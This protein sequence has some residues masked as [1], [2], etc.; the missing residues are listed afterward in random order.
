MDETDHNSDKPDDAC[1]LAADD[2][3]QPARRPADVAVGSS[4]GDGNRTPPR[5]DFWIPTTIAIIGLVVAVASAIFSGLQWHEANQLKK[6]TFRASVSFYFENDKESSVV[7]WSVLNSGP[8]PAKIQ[9]LDY[10][11]NNVRAK[12]FYDAVIMSGINSDLIGGMLYQEGDNLLV[13]KTD[14]IYSLKPK[15]QKDQIVD[16]FIDFA[17]D[18][19]GLSI[20]YCSI[21][22]ECETV[23]SWQ[24]TC[25]IDRRTN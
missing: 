21:A 13:G 4:Q 9:S 2:Q 19:L 8:G 18:H 6:L 1:K 23:C 3:S 7:G 24:G 15:K 14:W 16:R 25:S 12:D 11:V 22:G 17:G 10:F 20:R 5:S